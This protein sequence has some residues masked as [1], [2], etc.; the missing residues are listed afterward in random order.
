[1]T[2]AALATLEPRLNTLR[3]RS[4]SAL[5]CRT[6]ENDIALM[7]KRKEEEERRL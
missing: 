1:M 6:I 7:K 4:N 2:T 5:S 3:D